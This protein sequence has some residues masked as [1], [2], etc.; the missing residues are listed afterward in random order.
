MLLGNHRVFTADLDLEQSASASRSP[1]GLTCSQLAVACLSPPA[2]S[3][4]CQPSAAAL[5]L[6]SLHPSTCLHLNRLLSP[7]PTFSPHTIQSIMSNAG[8]FSSPAGAPWQILIYKPGSLV[9]VVDIGQILHGSRVLWWFF[10]LLFLQL[11]WTLS[12]WAI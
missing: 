11:S 5:T 3:S 4:S 12:L 1:A 2:L 10:F 7:P 8:L 6:F 9:T